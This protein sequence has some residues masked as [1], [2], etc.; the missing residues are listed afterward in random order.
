MVSAPSATSGSQVIRSSSSS[1][2]R[3]RASAVA[4]AGDQRLRGSVAVHEAVRHWHAH[5]V[6]ACARSLDGASLLTGG[7]EGVLVRWEAAG[8]GRNFLPRLGAPVR[9]VS[10]SAAQAG[11]SA[12]AVALP[13]LIAVGLA[14]CSVVMVDAASLKVL[15]R[16]RGL[17]LGGA[18]VPAALPSGAPS[19]TRGRHL[20]H[21]LA[22]DP[23]TGCVAV[24]SFPGRAALQLYDARLGRHAAEV[25]VREQTG[26]PRSHALI[27]AFAPS[28]CVLPLPM[29]CRS[30]RY[31]S[32]RRDAPRC[33]PG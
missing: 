26:S 32:Y 18:V 9:A 13:P 10:E 19:F 27:A 7:E 17:A 5:A 25:Q 15:W 31:A 24:N 6:A 4:E 12:A 8:A 2:L 22:V 11:A 20:R 16:A 23:R 33:R 1:S 14:D 30:S 21:G 3:G 29:P 28:L